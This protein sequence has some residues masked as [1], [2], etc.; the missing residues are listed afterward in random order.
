MTD[1]QITI[2]AAEPADAAALSALIGSEGVFEGTS[3]LPLMPIASRLERYSKVDPCGLLIVACLHEAQA[4]KI[5]GMLGLHLV[6]PGLRRAH[7][8]GLG[9]AIDSAWQG[10]GIGQRLMSA[11]MHGADNWAGILRIELTVFADNKRAI[12][13]Y[14]RHGFVREGVMQAHSMRDGVFADTLG[15]ARLH[16][17]PPQVS[18]SR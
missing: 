7:V 15:M 1:K 8:R 4:E 5:I 13:L 14:E 18:R 10:Q 9:I 17:K 6:Q 3:Q 2:R 12:A 16:P 11:A